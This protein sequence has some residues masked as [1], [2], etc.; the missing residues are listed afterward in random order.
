MLDHIITQSFLASNGHFWEAT[1]EKKKA[2]Q[3][4]PLEDMTSSIK[5]TFLHQRYNNTLFENHK[6]VSHTPNTH[7]L[8]TLIYFKYSHTPNTPTLPKFKTFPHFHIPTLPHSLTPNT[9]TLQT[10][11][12]SKHSQNSKI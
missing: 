6:K 4:R 11:P 7:A 12:H 2:Y 8:H 5:S 10:L 3:V 1:T 9:Q